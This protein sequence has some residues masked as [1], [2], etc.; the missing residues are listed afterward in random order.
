M[1]AIE[2]WRYDFEVYQLSANTIIVV[3]DVGVSSSPSN[4]IIC[5]FFNILIAGYLD[6]EY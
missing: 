3:I 6:F 5:S 1:L 2:T 4:K